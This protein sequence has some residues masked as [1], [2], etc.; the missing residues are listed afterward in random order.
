MHIGY[1]GPEIPA[2]SATFVYREIIGLRERGH[3]VSVYSVKEP[4]SLAR[5]VD[6][7]EVITLYRGG[8]SAT[9]KDAGNAIAQK[10]LLSLRLI[11]RGGKDTLVGMAENAA[12]AR[13]LPWHTLVGLKL[14]R[15]LQASGV[16]HLHIHFA[17][18]PTQI[19]MVAAAYAEIPFS[20][21]GHAND[22]YEVPLLL[23]EKAERS[24]SFTTISDYNRRMLIEAGLPA[25]QLAIVRCG[26][27]ALPTDL[28]ER[29]PTWA[30]VIGSVGRL[31]Q[32]KG[33]KELVQAFAELRHDHP[34]AKLEIIGDGPERE[35]IAALLKSHD[36][37]ADSVLKG[38]L[39]NTEVADWLSGLD[40]FVLACREDDRGDKDGIPVALMEAMRAG[41]PV[42]S[43]ELT[44]IPELIVPNE[45]GRLAQPADASS[46]AEAMRAAFTNPEIT[47]TL[48]Q[49]ALQHLH[50][51]F[52]L[53]VNLSRLEAIFDRTKP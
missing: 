13:A 47:E 44:G 48:R 21:M 31:V 12:R 20:L 52:S 7:G 36:L 16:E 32:K 25:S 15:L 5:D 26:V 9:L 3:Q 51:E 42:V 22:L 1:L 46:L 14:G 45:T 6:L 17:H 34:G 28:P 8:A 18:F 2:L 49:N 43:T 30:P 37:D 11:A 38:P 53:D 24:R 35:D 4:G 50:N 41:V 19:G 29:S 40:L 33:M 39:P 10:P 27:P 23:K